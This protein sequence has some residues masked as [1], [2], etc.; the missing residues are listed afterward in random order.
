MSMQEL[1]GQLEQYLGARSAL[2]LKDRGRK[3]LLQDFLRY[4]IEVQCDG[5]IPCHMAVDWAATTPKARGTGLAGPARRLSAVRG[6]MSHLR[7]SNLTSRFLRLGF[8]RQRRAG[9]PIY[10]RH[11]KLPIFS[12]Q[13]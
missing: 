4:L 13:H 10:I 8:S 1:R 6:F 3:S 5:S 12:R 2:G 9:V 7:A 11:S